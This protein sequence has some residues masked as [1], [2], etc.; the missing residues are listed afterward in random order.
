MEKTPALANTWAEQRLFAGLAEPYLLFWRHRQVLLAAVKQMLR[1]RFAGSLL[2]LVWLIVGPVILLV[3][4]AVTYA[5]I[6]RVRPNGLSVQ[7]YIFYI[8]SGLIPFLAFSM[9]L[10]SG[11]ASLATDRALLLNR[12]FPAALIPAR[13]VVAAGTTIVVGCGIIMLAKL[14]AGEA[15]WTWLLLPLVTLLLAMFTMGLVWGFAMGNLVVKDVQQLVGY[16][17]MI[18]AISSPIA[19]TPDMV[20]SSLRLL[21]WANPFA[22]FVRAFQSLLV[23]GQLPDPMVMLGCVLLALVSFH[24]MFKLFQ[25]GKRVI[26][27]HI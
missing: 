17:V 11:S 20:P 1:A 5:V 12:I 8:F 22:Y 18:L 24:G 13:D 10:N 25:V 2:G 4:Y 16:I 26:A 27:D 14:V 19:Y 3:L 6:F 7:D 15:S 9:A 21:I 23:L